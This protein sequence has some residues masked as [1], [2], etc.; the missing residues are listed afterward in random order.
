MIA[1]DPSLLVR[2]NEAQ[3]SHYPLEKIRQPTRVVVDS[4]EVV[5]SD[6]QCLTDGNTTLIATINPHPD[7]AARHYLTITP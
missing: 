5:N 4:K 2:A 3:F 6:Y 1:D 7:T